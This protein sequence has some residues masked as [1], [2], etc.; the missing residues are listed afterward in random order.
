MQVDAAA[1]AELRRLQPSLCG[2]GA[3]VNVG[4]LKLIWP[5]QEAVQGQVP[6]P[7]PGLLEAQAPPP[8][9]AQLPAPQ[10]PAAWSGPQHTLGSL[11]GGPASGRTVKDSEE[12]W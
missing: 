6:R 5:R 7:A 11:T 12:L 9:G 4:T 2:R 1:K 3:M 10:Q 8:G